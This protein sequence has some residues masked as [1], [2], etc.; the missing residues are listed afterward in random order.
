M[1]DEAD[2]NVV[3][4]ANRSVVNTAGMST[5]V[6]VVPTVPLYPIFKSFNLYAVAC[7]DNA[8]ATT[9]MFTDALPAFPEVIAIV[10]C[11]VLVEVKNDTMRF[12]SV[13]SSIWAMRCDPTDLTP[14]ITYCTFNVPSL[15]LYQLLKLAP[16]MVAMSAARVAVAPDVGITDVANAPCSS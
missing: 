10:D 9:V 1:F 6:S 14:S 4:V 11:V 12:V 2:P 7:L 16:T 5:E 13:P 3:L 8:P 15:W